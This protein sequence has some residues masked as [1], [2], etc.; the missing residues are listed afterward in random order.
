MSAARGGKLAPLLALALAGCRAPAPAVG[1]G[2]KEV[3]QTYFRALIRSDWARAHAAL[4]DQSRARCAA[5]RFADLAAIYR[6]GLGF[7]PE[8]VHVRSCEEHGDRAVAHV[9][10]TGRGK[11]YKDAVTLRRDGG[12]WGVVL[13]ARFGRN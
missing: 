9:I 13:P 6:R 10:L 11:R 3:V 4:E 1:T 8:E 2:S 12:V 7:E 5:N